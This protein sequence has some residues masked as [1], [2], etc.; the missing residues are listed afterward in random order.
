MFKPFNFLENN[1]LRVG[2]IVL[3]L[4]VF[5]TVLGTYWS[6]GW[7]S[8]TIAERFQF[9][10]EDKALAIERRMREQE[11]ALLGGVGLMNAFGNVTRAQWK[12]YVDGLRV[13]KYLPG[14]QGFGFATLIPPAELDRHIQSI[15]A[16]GF[17]DYT[18]NPPG[19]RDLYSAIVFLE[20]FSGRNLRAFGYDMWS[21]STRRVAMERARDTGTAA[22]S[23]MVTL[24]QENGSDFQRGFLMYLPVYKAGMPTATLAQRRAAI[25]GFVYSPYRI[26]D[27]MDGILGA[28]DREID[29]RIYDG[30]SK[31][32]DAIMYDSSSRSEDTGDTSGSQMLFLEVPIA[33]GGHDWLIEFRTHDSLVSYSEASQPHFVAAGGFVIVLLLFLAIWSFSNQRRQAKVMA[34]EMTR[35]LRVAKETAEMSAIA[36]TNQR[37]AAQKSNTMLQKAN[38]DLSRFNAIVA[39]D[40]RA[41][42]KRVEAFV[43]ILREDH[44]AQLG[45]EGADIIT[46][47]H[48]ST[49]CMRAMLD[50]LHSYSKLGTIDISTEPANLKSIVNN[51]IELLGS[52][53]SN[54]RIN[55]KIDDELMVQGNANLLQNVFLNLLSNA[56]K[57]RSERALMID[58]S[59]VCPLDDLVAITFTDN[60]IGVDREH[61]QKIFD[62]FSRLHDPDEYEGTGIGLAVC[63][64]IMTDH[65]GQIAYDPAYEGGACFNLVLKCATSAQSESRD[66]LVA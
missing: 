15:R 2:W 11:A 52:E 20:P 34:T 61:A 36:E 31:R 23:G 44:E 39:H 8:T 1:S 26:G 19:K 3:G 28:G 48:R 12:A 64:K 41:P 47:L 7:M 33:I 38:Q 54:A 66:R 49:S 4:S 53:L 16:E 60:G 18:V 29:F 45:D 24:V 55:V 10:A 13:D 62:M 58:I 30:L 14:I 25:T 22:V 21:Q 37:R 59:A 32:E 57:F 9:K 46:R 5:A 6:Y 40:L 17:P 56:A 35:E 43:S 51:A 27:L 42:L 50:S 65:G 63:R